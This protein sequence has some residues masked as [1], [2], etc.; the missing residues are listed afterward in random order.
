[1]YMTRSPALGQ[2]CVS[3]STACRAST[4][5]GL[6]RYRNH[7]MNIYIYRERE[8]KIIIN[9]YIYKYKYMNM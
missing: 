3:P 2:R 1:M 5:R 4:R 6:F 9:K 7:N 8:R